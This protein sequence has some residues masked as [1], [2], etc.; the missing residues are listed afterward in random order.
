MKGSSKKKDS[1]ET[2]G[3]AIE[4]LKQIP[5]FKAEAETYGI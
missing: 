5:Y 2:E 1:L 3:L 4:I